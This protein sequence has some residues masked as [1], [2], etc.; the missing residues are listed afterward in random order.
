M[1][2]GYTLLMATFVSKLNIVMIIQQKNINFIFL[3]ILSPILTIL[4]NL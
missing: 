4:E 1:Y 3:F 2:M